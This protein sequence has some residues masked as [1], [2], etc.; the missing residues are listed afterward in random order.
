MLA[1]KDTVLKTAATSFSVL[2][3][4]ETGTGKSKIAA[5][6]HRLS[7]RKGPFVE[8]NCSAIPQELFE[9]ELFGHEKGSFTGATEK[10]IG[11]FELADGG[12]LFLDEIGDMPVNQQA[13]ILKVLDNREICRIGAKDPVKINV[14]VIAAT[15]KVIQE[16][17]EKKLLREDLYFRL[18]QV[19]INIPSLR[20]RCEDIPE[21]AEHA[22]KKLMHDFPGKKIHGISTAVIDCLRRHVW[23]GNIRELENIIRHALM[24]C[25]AQGEIQPEHLPAGATEQVKTD[26]SDRIRLVREP[27]GLNEMERAKFDALLKAI[28][29]T[30]SLS[31]AAKKLGIGKRWI[32]KLTK[33]YGIQVSRRRSNPIKPQAL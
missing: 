7:S 19:C 3:L 13:K 14:R 23:R 18:N 4:G 27:D 32:I 15:N 29:E 30:S 6:I 24:M 9:S 31:E 20:E 1:I 17:V 2:L 5:E 11:K 28:E 26:L 25:P 21:L 8:L 22:L 10:K 12:T 16:A 33:K